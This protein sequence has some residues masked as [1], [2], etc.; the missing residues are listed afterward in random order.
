MPAIFNIMAVVRY[1]HTPIYNPNS[2]II[3]CQR[4]KQAFVKIVDRYWCL[5]DL[6]RGVYYCYDRCNWPRDPVGYAECFI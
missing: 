5:S 1:N 4:V 6:F 2:I 3:P